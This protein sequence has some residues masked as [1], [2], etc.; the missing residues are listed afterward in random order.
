MPLAKAKKRMASSRVMNQ[1]HAEGRAHR[2]TAAEAQ[3]AVRKYWKS[4]KRSK[5]LGGLALGLKSKKKKLN[6]AA[7]RARYTNNQTHGVRFL[8]FFQPP[9]IYDGQEQRRGEGVWM[10]A[11]PDG[12]E[13]ILSERAALI[14]LGHIPSTKQYTPE[15]IVR[16]KGGSGSA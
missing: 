15:E 7:L 16:K 13:R 3:A 6:H 1:L 8:P 5:R 10:L 11:L 14:R 9:L 4:V 2:W 12:T